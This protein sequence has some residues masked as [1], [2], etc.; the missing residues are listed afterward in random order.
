MKYLKTVCSQT[1]SLKGNSSINLQI[2]YNRETDEVRADEVIG[3][4]AWIQ[5]S[6]KNWVVIGIIKGPTTMN[7]IEEMVNDKMDYI[8][9]IEN[10]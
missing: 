10:R 4:N 1:K 2:S 9:S 6:D 8:R 7:E 3:C 5:F